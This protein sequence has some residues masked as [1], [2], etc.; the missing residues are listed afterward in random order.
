MKQLLMCSW[1]SNWSDVGPLALRLATGAIFAMHGYQKLMGGVDPLAGFLASLGFPMPA[2]FAVLLIVAELGGG[3][4]LILG[5]LTHW[6]AKVLVVV[7]VVALVTV[8]LANGFF[9]NEGGY[10]F[11]MLILA[12]SISLMFTGAGKWSVD[13]VLKKQ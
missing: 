5:A 6:T 9:V 4:L 7:S 3:I 2:L 8:H 11:I 1:C 10:E 13:H 12:A